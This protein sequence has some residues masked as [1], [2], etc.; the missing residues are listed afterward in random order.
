MRAK[1]PGEMTKCHRLMDPR[2]CEYTPGPGSADGP[3]MAVPPAVA[4]LEIEICLSPGAVQAL[5][6]SG[7]AGGEGVSS[8][9]PH[10][11][12][13]R[14]ASPHAPRTG[15]SEPSPPPATSG[16]LFPTK[17]KGLLLPPSILGLLRT[18]PPAPRSCSPLH[19]EGRLTLLV[20]APAQR[21]QLQGEESHQ[22]PGLIRISGAA[23]T[24]PVTNWGRQNHVQGCDLAESLLLSNCCLPSQK[25][26]RM[27]AVSS[28]TLLSAPPPLPT[29]AAL[30]G[31]L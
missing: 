23:G 14:V 8:S 2:V 15:P 29:A 21:L 22:P 9:A 1:L 24:A 13:G 18:Q 25:P 28:G 10:C 27:A 20:T 31:L 7:N 19:G 30:H 6:C 16:P 12:R 11:L 26:S 4:P 5:Q 3:A 17:G